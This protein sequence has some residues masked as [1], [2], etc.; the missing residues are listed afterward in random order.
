L[1]T[2]G[3]G[4]CGAVFTY[5]RRT[6]ACF[7]DLDLFGAPSATR[8]VTVRIDTRR[9]HVVAG[10]ATARAGS[11]ARIAYEVS[12]PRSSSSA[13]FVRVAPAHAGCLPRAVARR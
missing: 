9:P 5:H 8:N 7:R 10:P 12:D 1:S 2:P 13:A 3:V 4:G 11:V 6:R